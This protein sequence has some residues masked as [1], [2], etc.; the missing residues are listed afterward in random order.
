MT[1]LRLSEWANIAEMVGA[2][3]VV[4]SLLYVGIQINAN[5]VEVRA[6]SRQQLINRSFIATHNVATSPELAGVLTKVAEG[7]QL[8]AQ[9]LTQYSYFVRGM[10]YDIQE[11][12]FLYSEGRLDEGYWQTR[13]AIFMAYMENPAARD[14]YLRDKKLT[15]LHPEFVKWVDHTIEQ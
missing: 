6:A 9:E 4:V 12:Y 3:A 15:V 8:T 11:A 2:V 10:L 7:T 5:T 1:R 13:I 14:V